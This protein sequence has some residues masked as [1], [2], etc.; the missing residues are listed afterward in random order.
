M[1]IP[2]SPPLT[3]KQSVRINDY[4]RQLL[5]Y[6]WLHSSYEHII[7]ICA[8]TCENQTYLHKIHLFILQYVSPL[9][10]KILEL[11]KLHEIS[12]EKLNN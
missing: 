12:Y 11:Y 7:I 8:T 5:P 6:K 9:L 10:F 3:L 1:E 4:K 2:Q